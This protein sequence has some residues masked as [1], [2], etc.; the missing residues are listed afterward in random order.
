MSVQKVLQRWILFA[1]VVQSENIKF[2]ENSQELHVHSAR[3]ES[4]SLRRP[5]RVIKYQD[6]ITAASAT[7]DFCPIGYKYVN[8][9]SCTQCPVSTYQDENRLFSSCKGCQPSKYNNEEGQANCNNNLCTCLG[10]GIPASGTDCTTNGADICGCPLGEVLDAT[11]GSCSKCPLGK[12]SIGFK[13]PCIKCEKGKYQDNV[14]GAADYTCLEC[15][16]GRN[17]PNEGRSECDA[18]PTCS[19]FTSCVSGTHHLKDSAETIICATATCS[20]N[21]CCT[22]NPTCKDFSSCIS[23]I[24]HLNSDLTNTC[25]SSTCSASDCCT[26]NPTCGNVGSTGTVFS[27]CF[28]G[29]NHLRATPGSI[30]CASENCTATDCCLD[31]PTCVSA[32]FKSSACTADMNWLKN[33]LT[34]ITCVSSSCTDL[35]CCTTQ[36]Y[37]EIE[38]ADLEIRISDT[39]NFENTDDI[40]YEE[41]NIEFVSDIE[42]SKYIEIRFVW[43]AQPCGS[44][45]DVSKITFGV[46]SQENR[47]SLKD[48]HENKDKQLVK[49]SNYFDK[50]TVCQDISSGSCKIVIHVEEIAPEIGATSIEYAFQLEYTST[51][52]GRRRRDLRRR[53]LPAIASHTLTALITVKSLSDFDGDGHSDK[54]EGTEDTDGDGIPDYKDTDSDGDGIL[55][56]DEIQGRSKTVDTETTKNGNDDGDDDEDDDGDDKES[57]DVG[58]GNSGTNNSKES[59]SA[60]ELGIIIGGVAIL[61]CCC[62][63]LFLWYCCYRGKKQEQQEGSQQQE[64]MTETEMRMELTEMQ[65]SSNSSWQQ[66]A[67]L[68][69]NLAKKQMSMNILNKNNLNKK[70]DRR[71]KNRSD[72]LPKVKKKFGQRKIKIA[73]D[74]SPVFQTGDENPLY[75]ANPLH[76][77]CTINTSMSD[78]KT[79]TTLKSS[80]SFRKH[81][82]DEGHEYFEDVNSGDTTWVLPENAEISEDKKNPLYPTMED[83]SDAEILVKKKNSFRRLNTSDGGREYFQNVQSP[84]E[85]TWVLPNDATIVQ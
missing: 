56:K 77:T 13:S 33:D 54:A 36:C 21:E 67:Y 82:S 83:T 59:E 72:N 64:V 47:E 20:V 43:S 42:S 60:M 70:N 45:V 66:D 55:D 57:N 39:I 19:D 74:S 15:A 84:D 2:L 76:P 69:S 40:S 52:G 28:N 46:E 34:G 63:G 51:T 11:V 5:Q 6:Q 80:K 1:V 10:G 26:L 22:L 25:E 71:R 73:K 49:P 31:N 3:W 12:A 35:D 9:S 27:S 81:K 37:P 4:S 65:H 62:F 24:N 44:T 8:T 61:V 30:T 17:Q 16:P 50:G 14:N 68:D 48:M 23:G 18:N 29:K 85:T 53:Q 78:G 38:V 32:D 41:G 7:C 79:L 75:A 58:I